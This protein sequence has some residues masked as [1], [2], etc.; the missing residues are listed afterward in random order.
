MPYMS[1]TLDVSKLSGWLNADASCGVGG[2]IVDR[3]TQRAQGARGA[4]SGGVRGA[5]R[6]HVV[7][8]CDAGRVPT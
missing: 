5:H 8:G 6:K 2:G 1:V 4:F 7:H 3:N